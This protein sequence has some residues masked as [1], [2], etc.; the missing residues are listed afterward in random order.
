MLIFKKKFLP[1]WVAKR[2]RLVMIWSQSARHFFKTAFSSNCNARDTWVAA[3][4]ALIIIAQVG[5]ASDPCY[6]PAF[7]LTIAS[8]RSLCRIRS[9]P[10]VKRS[11]EQQRQLLSSRNGALVQASVGICFGRRPVA[12]NDGA[13]RHVISSPIAAAY[14]R[15][16]VGDHIRN[17]FINACQSLQSETGRYTS[18]VC[19]LD[20]HHQR[21]GKV[22]SGKRKN[23]SSGSVLPRM[24]WIDVNKC[25]FIRN[26][27]D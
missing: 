25:I 3:S 24:R 16:S 14:H 11:P 8:N 23:G 2:T 13:W 15:R 20:F 26:D 18:G 27:S 21:A 10:G 17:L 9:R 4:S 19:K 22:K 6:R 12:S 1:R 7:K 5:V